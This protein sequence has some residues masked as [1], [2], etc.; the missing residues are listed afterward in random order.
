M[1]IINSKDLKDVKTPGGD[2]TIVHGKLVYY[3]FKENYKVL[4]EKYG[5]VYGGFAI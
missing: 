4:R 5:V 3:Y 2:G 1:L